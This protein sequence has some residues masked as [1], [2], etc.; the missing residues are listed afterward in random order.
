MT[1]DARVHSN[2]SKCNVSTS[3]FAFTRA[4]LSLYFLAFLLLG[5]GELRP[6][7]STVQPDDST[8][9][10][11]LIYVTSI[12]STDLL[13]YPDLKELITAHYDYNTKHLSGVYDRRLSEGKFH[14]GRRRPDWNQSIDYWK[15]L[16]LRDPPG[17]LSQADIEFIEKVGLIQT[18]ALLVVHEGGHIKSFTRAM[19]SE[20]L[21]SHLQKQISGEFEEGELSEIMDRFWHLK[22][23]DDRNE[24][25]RW[26]ENR[27]LD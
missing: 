19:S 13:D 9:R 4:S 12:G 3:R 20:L 11:S 22:N 1:S 7:V 15:Y 10:P 26:L 5:C 23:P 6:D 14:S 16:T 24:L 21:T 27:L 17:R 25:K 18:P 2:E 8:V